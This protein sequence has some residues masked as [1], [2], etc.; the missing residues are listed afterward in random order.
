MRRA[1]GDPWPKVTPLAV[2]SQVCNPLL[3]EVTPK[4][5]S[6]PFVQN[7]SHALLTFYWHPAP[8]IVAGKLY[9]EQHPL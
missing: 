3:S 8:H 2:V 9:P 7:I 5:M 6:T 1:G 4:L